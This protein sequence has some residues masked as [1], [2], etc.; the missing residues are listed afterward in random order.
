MSERPPPGVKTTVLASSSKDSYL[1]PVPQA[2]G[3]SRNRPGRMQPH[4]RGG[5]RGRGRGALAGRVPPT[6]TKPF[7]LV[8][9]GNSNFA[10]NS[11]FPYVSNGDLAVEMVRWLAGDEARPAAKPQSFSPAQQI[12]ADEQTRC[13]TSS[14]WSS[15][16]CR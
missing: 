2:P 14:S 12:D 10:T 8:L 6:Q 13:A 5:A 11:Y 15:S 1:R 7:R 16:S 9:V 3:G 4:G